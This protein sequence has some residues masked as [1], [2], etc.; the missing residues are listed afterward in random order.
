MKRIDKIYNYVKEKSENV[1]MDKLKEIGGF[2]AQE[3]GEDLNI[4]R[5]N[6]SKELNELCRMRKLIKIKGRPVLYFHRNSLENLIQKKIPEEILELENISEITGKYEA[7]QEISPFHYLIGAE[8]SLKNQIEQAKAAILYPPNGLHT[9]IVG[10]TGV[11]KTLFANMMYNYAR[12]IDKL[13]KDAPFVVF[14]CADYYNNPQLLLSHIFGHIKGAFTGADTE[15][16]G[17]VEKANGGILFLDEIHRLPPEGQEMLFYFMDTG[18]YNKLGET[19]RKRKAN[20]FIIGATTED[21]A[22]ALLKTFIRR[23]PITITIPNFDERPM[24]D[25]VDIIKH[26]LSN[27]AHRVNKAIKISSEAVKALIGSTSYGNIGQLKSNIQL[28]CAKGFLNSINTDNCIEIDFKTLPNNI[29]N[30][31]I[32]MG[33]RRKESEELWRLVPSHLVITP[34]GY[35]ELIEE[36]PYEP[37]F[38]LYKIIEDKAAVLREEGMDNES[39]NKFITTD[40]NV[41]IKCFYDKFKTDGKNRERILKIVDNDIL[42]FAE[43][44]QKVAEER[45]NR[46]FTDRFLYALSLHLSAFFNRI[47][48]KTELKHTNVDSIVEDNPKEYKV[49][50]EVKTMIEERFKIKV[51]KPEVM[52]LTLL[53]SSA[54]DTTNTGRVA[55]IVAAHGN[56]TASSMVGVVKKLLEDENVEAI[57]M[58]LEVSPKEILEKITE[59]VKERERGKGA[60]ILVDMGSLTGFGSIIT[61]K[62][63]IE[64]RTLEMVSTPLVLEAVR[65]SSIFEMDLDSIYNSLKDFKGYTSQIEEKVKPGEGVIVTLCTTG[66]GAALKLKK[67]V[68]DIVRNVSEKPVKIVPIGIKNMKED[69]DKI[70]EE[71]PILATVGAINPKIEAPFISLENLI[72]GDGENIIK[73]IVRGHNKQDKG[74][75][76]QN[77]VVKELCEDS[78]K[79]FLTYLNPEKIISVLIEF[80][81]VLEKSFEKEFSNSMK[82]RLMLHTA[83]ALERMVIKDGLEY[84][85]DKEK[86]HRDM[87][88]VVKGACDIFKE[89]L[90]IQLTEDEIYYIVEMFM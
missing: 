64:T 56:S 52:Y 4:L 65:K 81:S 82:I 42:A 61:E 32:S 75:E 63:G 66:E 69:L 25:K 49:A 53:L 24:E 47:Q 48:K 44:V 80:V 40:I 76:Q 30:G 28:I 87:L 79:Q 35:K 45:L 20:V 11:G 23:I 70:A 74:H 31:L 62:T 12:Y 83:C 73:N 7:N 55:V 85:Y 50:V 36:D 29:K 39:I 89:K 86:I 16:Q 78:L 6:A 27:E 60:L 17:L 58:P 18:T 59:K 41:H 26:L 9:L 90:N 51:P 19:E 15:K 2:S 57:D 3:I 22:S 34:Q 13:S 33:A 21:P 54:G 67:L 1:S 84:K 46:K 77:I 8:N 14:N 37:P 5:N 68:E 71:Q 10:Q 38:N 43:E 88:K 72:N